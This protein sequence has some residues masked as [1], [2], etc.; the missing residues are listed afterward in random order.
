MLKQINDNKRLSEHRTTDHY[1]Q[2]KV[3]AHMCLKF[4]LHCQRG[5]LLSG[6]LYD[7]LH[8]PQVLGAPKPT[9]GKTASTCL[10]QYYCLDM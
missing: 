6:E 9:H 7:T 4:K 10:D 1:A 5:N 2:Y 3:M 8:T